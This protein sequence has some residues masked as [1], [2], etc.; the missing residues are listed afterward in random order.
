MKSLGIALAA[1][2]CLLGVKQRWRVHWAE[3]GAARV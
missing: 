1:S 3:L 2:L